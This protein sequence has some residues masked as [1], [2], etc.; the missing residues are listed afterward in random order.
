[1]RDVHRGTWVYVCAP[2]PLLCTATKVHAQ[3]WELGAQVHDAEWELGA[4]V[5]DEGA[6]GRIAES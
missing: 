2:F 1:M 6:G 5:H 4:Q 3:E